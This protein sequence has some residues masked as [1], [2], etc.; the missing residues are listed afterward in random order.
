MTNADAKKAV[1]IAIKYD[2]KDIKS[3]A[4]VAAIE[5]REVHRKKSH[6]AAIRK[7]KRLAKRTARRTLKK[8]L[9]DAD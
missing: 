9:W 1:D 5:G 6:A 2:M 7:M 3:I 8:D 4:K